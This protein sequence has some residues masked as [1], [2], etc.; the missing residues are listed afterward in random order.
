MNEEKITMDGISLVAGLLRQ[1]DP[2]FCNG[3]DLEVAK[4]TMFCYMTR[5]GY[6]LPSGVIT[7]GKE[8]TLEDV[9]RAYEDGY[10]A[11]INDGKLLGF[12]TERA[13]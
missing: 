8:V 12:N 7:P 13:L 1:V 10:S 6:R 5:F 3:S 2:E 11:I 4:Y 9:E